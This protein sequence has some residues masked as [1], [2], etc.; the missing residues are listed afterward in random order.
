MRTR[1]DWIVQRKMPFRIVSPQCD[2]DALNNRFHIYA[3]AATAVYDYGLD[4]YNPDNFLFSQYQYV[5]ERKACNH[6]AFAA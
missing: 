2:W 6:V 1:S 4:M 5:G 3:T